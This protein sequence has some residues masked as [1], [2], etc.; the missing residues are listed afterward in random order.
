[1]NLSLSQNRAYEVLK[2]SLSTIKKSSSK[3]VIKRLRSRGASS[4]NPISTSKKKEDK[5]LSRRVEFK[6]ILKNKHRV[7]Q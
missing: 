6:V 3:W 5:R 1:M 4:S 2:H 7:V